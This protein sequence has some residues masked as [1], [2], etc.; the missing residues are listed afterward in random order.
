MVRNPVS[1]YPTL[2]LTALSTKKD[3][4]MQYLIF[5]HALIISIQCLFACF[6][7]PDLHLYCHIIH[8]RIFFHRNFNAGRNI[9]WVIT[10]G[11]FELKFAFR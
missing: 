3:I 1:V 4:Y 8:R 10:G 9:L 5:S 6:L 2:L 7:F 11:V